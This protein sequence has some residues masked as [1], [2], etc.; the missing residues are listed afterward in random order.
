MKSVDY[1]KNIEKAGAGG[2]GRA[3]DMQLTYADQLIE[4]MELL[5]EPVG[6]SVLTPQDL[7]TYI[8]ITDLLRENIKESE[9]EAKKLRDRMSEATAKAATFSD[10]FHSGISAVNEIYTGLER[11]SDLFDKSITK[12]KFKDF[13]GAGL[14]IS[15]MLTGGAG[16]LSIF[17]AAKGMDEIVTKPTLI[18]AGEAGKE[19]VKITPA[20]QINSSITT[21]SNISSSTNSDLT[22]NNNINKNVIMK[23]AGLDKVVDKTTTIVPTT[24]NKETMQAAVYNIADNYNTNELSN[25][26]VNNNSSIVNNSEIN[27]FMSLISDVIKNNITSQSDNYQDRKNILNKNSVVK[28][29]KN[30]NLV[31]SLQQIKNIE[32]LQNIKNKSAT[33]RNQTTIFAAASGMDS[34]VNSPTLILAGESGREQ[35]KITPASQISSNSNT[36]NTDNYNYLNKFSELHELSNI[37]N[38]NFGGNNY[39]DNS[40]MKKVV[41]PDNSSINNIYNNYVNLQQPGGVTDKQVFS[42]M[43]NSIS[44]Q[45]IVSN[46]DDTKVNYLKKHSTINNIFAAASGM[47]SIVNSPTLILAGESGS[48]QV[49]ITPAPVTNNNKTENASN[50]LIINVHGNFT[51]VDKLADELVYRSQMGFNKIQVNA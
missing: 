33:N 2:G 26:A 48:E 41:S 20:S 18:L 49:K 17:G 38:V 27:S 14:N 36:V 12:W 40:S 34:I 6:L 43:T 28:S 35:V 32:S 22:K 24:T 45:N 7:D 1:I 13:L 8:T 51:D 10:N 23:G 5:Q 3:F 42:A 25:T 19:H 21:T 44:K 16:L 9:N 47:D 39:N 11:I 50:T 31:E 15:G 37:K 29:S 4:K 46:F 30:T